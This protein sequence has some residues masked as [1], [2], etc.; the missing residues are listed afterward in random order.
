MDPD[1]VGSIVSTLG[2]VGAL[3]WYLY[4]NTTKTIPEMQKQYLD[5]QEKIIEKHTSSQERIAQDF[6]ETLQTERMYRKEE[7][8]QLKTWIEK[9]AACK[10]NADRSDGA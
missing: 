2:V 9:E 3:V 8:E 1:T 7:I 10:Y 4:H 6:G 5:S